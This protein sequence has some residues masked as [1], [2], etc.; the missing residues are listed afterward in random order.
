M[1]S[2]PTPPTLPVLACINHTL[3]ST[4]RF[5]NAAL[6]IGLPWVAVLSLINIASL[7]AMRGGD[8]AA[9]TK[10]IGGWPDLVLAAL[11]IVAASSVAVNWHRFILRDELPKS[12]GEA[13]R[14]DAPV[15]RY[16]GYTLAC[17]FLVLLPVVVLLNI[18]LS[19]TTLIPVVLGAS[20]LAGILFMRL[21]VALPAKALDQPAFGMRQA[22]EATR[23]N[24]LSFAG[25]VF[26]NAAIIL[27]ALFVMGLLITVL[28]QL[29]TPIFI[30]GS[31]IIS[32]AANLFVT[33]F[34]ASLLSSLYGFFVEN[35]RF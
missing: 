26:V 28:M 33:L 3:T 13:M 18:S 5:R 9:E 8:F 30:I 21:S 2:N 22:M 23:N 20:I 35:R 10:Q 7:V 12:L 4:L 29:P 25:I 6:T 32:M 19:F 24:M 14:L 27:A 34:G 11:S 15:W 31:A 16:A 1:N 17:L